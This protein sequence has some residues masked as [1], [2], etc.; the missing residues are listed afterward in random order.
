MI[1]KSEHG[2]VCVDNDL[3]FDHGY[4][5]LTYVNYDTCHLSTKIEGQMLDLYA[6][7]ACGVY[8][9]P[10]TPL[11]STYFRVLPSSP[12]KAYLV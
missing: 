4:T 6:Q 8:D 2:D 1:I 12:I 11:R 7:H 3:V 10:H 9:A 5:N